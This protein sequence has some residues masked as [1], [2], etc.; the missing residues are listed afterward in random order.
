[1]I[2]IFLN[3]NSLVV[4]SFGF[5]VGDAVRDKVLLQPLCVCGAAQAKSKEVPFINNYCNYV[6]HGF[7]KHLYGFHWQKK[8]DRRIAEISQMMVDHH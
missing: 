4:E 8:R 7:M 6:D 3:W 5:T 1:M 2:R